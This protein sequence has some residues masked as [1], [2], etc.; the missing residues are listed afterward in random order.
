MGCNCSASARRPAQAA[1]VPE[2][3]AAASS[4]P[5]AASSPPAVDYASP[6]SLYALLRPLKD[7]PAPVR[8]LKSAFILTLAVALRAATTDEERMRLAM[9]RRQELEEDDPDAFYTA[10]EVKALKGSTNDVAGT[11][12]IAVV[13]VSHCW[14][15]RDHPDPYGDTIVK[16]ADTIL[17]QQKNS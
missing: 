2:A 7:G 4:G 16:L 1:S 8:L 14:A 5:E 13:S 9:K 15:T 10:E 11:Y 12:P 3:S 6:E 17:A